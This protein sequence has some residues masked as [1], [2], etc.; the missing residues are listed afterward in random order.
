MMNLR[1]LCGM[2]DRPCR[3]CRGLILF[4]R[5]GTVMNTVMDMC[6]NVTNWFMATKL[7]LF[8]SQPLT[9]NP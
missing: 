7:R 5:K 9:I 2:I 6:I 1:E 8:V 4:N 3:V